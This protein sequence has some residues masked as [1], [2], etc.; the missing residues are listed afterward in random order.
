MQHDAHERIAAREWN[1]LSH[2][3]PQFREPVAT[4]SGLS[5]AHFLFYRRPVRFGTETIRRRRSD[6]HNLTDIPLPRAP[7]GIE[8]AEQLTG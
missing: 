4:A 6:P 1:S 3:T 5:A 7:S 8:S 2:G